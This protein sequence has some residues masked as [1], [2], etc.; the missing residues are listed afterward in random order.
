MLAGVLALGAC[1]SPEADFSASMWYVTDVWEVNSFNWQGRSGDWY[2]QETWTGFRMRAAPGLRPWGPGVGVTRGVDDATFTLSR[3]SVD[4]P[5]TILYWRTTYASTRPY[6]A[7]IDERIITDACD[8]TSAR[9]DLVHH[10]RNGRDVVVCS[11]P[12]IAHP[13]LTPEFA[14][15]TAREDPDTL[16]ASQFYLGH[17]VVRCEIIARHPSPRQI[18]AF[19]D[20]CSSVSASSCTSTSKIRDGLHTYA[21]CD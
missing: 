13:G 16:V 2:D 10:W 8:P 15:R 11:L 5:L 18:D 21:T 19:I 12:P 4:L 9:P 20:S 7:V 14:A 6:E 3:S 17:T 1:R